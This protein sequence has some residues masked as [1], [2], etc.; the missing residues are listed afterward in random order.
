[1][2]KEQM[3]EVLKI[4]RPAI[5]SMFGICKLKVTG[6]NMLDLAIYPLLKIKY[7]WITISDTSENRKFKVLIENGVLTYLQQMKENEV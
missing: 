3:R 4:A 5:W 1:M 6:F 7:G 2:T